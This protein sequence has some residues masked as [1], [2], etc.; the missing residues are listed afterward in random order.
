MKTL[1]SALFI[2]GFSLISI[3]YSSAQVDSTIYSDTAIIIETVDSLSSSDSSV[4]NLVDT[5]IVGD[6]DAP[7]VIEEP[8]FNPTWNLGLRLVNGQTTQILPKKKL[9]FCIQHRFGPF[10]SGGYNWYGL[11]Q[12]TIR[13][14]FDYGLN[15]QLTVGIGRASFGKTVNGYAKWAMTTEA[16]GSFVN[17]TLYS[18]M[19]I[20]GS[21][22]TSTITPYY[23]THRLRFT[24][25]LILSKSLLKHRLWLQVA[26][27]IIHRNLTDSIKTPNDLPF[28]VLST[29]VK[30]NKLISLTAEYNY[31]FNHD[32]R[33]NNYPAMGAG[34]EFY[35]AGHVFQVTFSNTT[36]L[37][38]S[39]YLLSDNGKIAKGNFGMGFNIVRRF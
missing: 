28:M 13:L 18:S 7:F 5:F 3:Q 36:A 27:T 30:I 20:N 6:G 15:N 26:P 11:D 8:E 38:E 32:F 4:T 9:E 34:I 37:N 19:D 33:K 35:T 24:N 10:S 23:F 22:V 17:A 29:R 14:G 2:V 16:K 12:S 21:K 39:N 31:T 1:K 25:Q